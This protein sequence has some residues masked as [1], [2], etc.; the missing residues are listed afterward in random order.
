MVVGAGLP[1]DLPDLAGLY[2][3]GVGALPFGT[4]IRPLRELIERLLSQ[5]LAI[6]RAMAVLCAWI[7][8]VLA[9]CS[10]TLE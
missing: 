8:H 3:R 10:G 2:F 7:G 1:L 9:R 5:M 4:Q 6:A